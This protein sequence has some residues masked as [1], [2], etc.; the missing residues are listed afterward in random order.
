MGY[1]I[2]SLLQPVFLSSL[3]GIMLFPIL[4]F[5]DESLFLTNVFL[6]AGLIWICIIISLL[7]IRVTYAILALFLMGI[8]IPFVS[9]QL[10]PQTIRFPTF[11]LQSDMQIEVQEI[12]IQLNK[13]LIRCQALQLSYILIFFY[14]LEYLV[15]AIFIIA[16]PSLVFLKKNPIKASSNSDFHRLCQKVAEEMNVK[17]PK[18]YLLTEP[19]VISFGHSERN[20]VIGIYEKCDLSG[21]E[22]GPIFVHEFSHIKSDVRF[23]SLHHL[24]NK[25]HGKFNFLTGL[26]FLAIVAWFISMLS[27]SLDVLSNASQIE[28]ISIA[29]NNLAP[30]YIAVLYLAEIM[31]FKAI[32]SLNLVVLNPSPQ[33][34]EFRADLMTFLVVGEEKL[35]NSI[36]SLRGLKLQYLLEHPQLKT[37][38]LSRINNVYSKI[39]RKIVASKEYSSWLDYFKESFRKSVSQ[40]LNSPQDKLRVDF[41]KFVNKLVNENVSFRQS[42][43]KVDVGGL[44][45]IKTSLFSDKI[46]LYEFDRDFRKISIS[47]KRKVVGYLLNNLNKFNAKSCSSETN[48]KLFDV[49]VVITMLLVD[50]SI[51]LMMP[52]R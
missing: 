49:I 21:D 9:V 47:D 48:V 37:S 14:L 34:G 20:A 29:I 50:G 6:V 10:I 35:V 22:L 24:L 52:E 33:I 17:M 25:F 13:E 27:K 3:I 44:W 15:Y 36:R 23:H 2:L 42:K 7:N 19:E 8:F 40:D 45:K 30:F 12:S 18:L 26:A 5:A 51:S 43:D 16:F 46:A 38:F 39:G 4:L 32:L 31:L 11:E 41:I 1:K 28:T